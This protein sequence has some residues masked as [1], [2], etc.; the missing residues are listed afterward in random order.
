MIIKRIRIIIRKK[1]QKNFVRRMSGVPKQVR[2][3]KRFNFAPTHK[4]VEDVLKDHDLAALGD[5]YT[6][7]VYSLY[8]SIRIGKPTG[9]KA[10][11]QLLSKAL[12]QAGLRVRVS[13]R[14][15]RHRQADAAEALLAYAWLQGHTTIMESVRTLS[16]CER[17]VDAF[18]SL[19]VEAKK[20]LGL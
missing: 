11:G 10:S 8:L 5:A 1:L 13:P 4:T 17:V 20:R 7:L 16:T 2:A 18:S 12:K 14:S 6:N 19:L 3:G 9:A 15:D